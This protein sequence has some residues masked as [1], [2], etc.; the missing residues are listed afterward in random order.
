V[1][2]QLEAV[3]A[4]AAA[5]IDPLYTTICDRCGQPARIAF[6][7]YSQTFECKRCLSPIPLFDCEHT[8]ILDGDERKTIANCP[9]CAKNGHIEQISTRGTKTGVIPVLT[10]YH[11]LGSCRPT[12]RERRH[13]DSDPPEAN[14]L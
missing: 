8:E 2:E 9:L 7:V 11:C 1:R 6:T 12:L 3:K 4:R 14:R 13:N 5:E 10:V